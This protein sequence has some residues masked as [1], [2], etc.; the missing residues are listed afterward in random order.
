MKLRPLSMEFLRNPIL[1]QAYAVM[2]II[3]AITSPAYADEAMSVAQSLASKWQNA[4]N[5]G[6][7]GKVADLYTQDAVWSRPAGIVKGKSEIEKT[8]TDAMKRDWGK[9]TLTPA[10]A[11]QNGNVI[12]VYGD[13]SF[14]NGPSGHYGIVDVSEG[15]FWHI[16]MDVT[17]MMPPKKE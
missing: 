14:A 3:V 5:S 17:N 1:A 11:H 13:W 7:A 4:Y 2:V 16:A 8:L 6:D 15:G 12:W 9:L 10:A